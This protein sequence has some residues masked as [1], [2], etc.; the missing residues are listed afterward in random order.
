MLR[1]VVVIGILASGCGDPGVDGDASTD[2]AVDPGAGESSKMNGFTAAHNAV[3]GPLGLDNLRWDEDLADE[4]DSWTNSLVDDDCAFEHNFGS[5][6]G[7]NLYWSSFNSDPQQVVTS[8]ASEEVFYDYDSNGCQANQMCGH[9]TQIVWAD[10][11]HLGCAMNKC[12]DDS[13][14][15]MCVYDPAGNWIGEW[16]Y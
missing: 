13:Q 12:A 9:Y 7:E 8:W 4:A 1:F 6:Y 16:P 15:W 2:E 10:T 11:A 3:R 14:I 5:P